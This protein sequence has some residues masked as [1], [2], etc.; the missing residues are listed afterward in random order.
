MVRILFFFLYC[1]A[2]LPS[3]AQ[4][5]ILL[6]QKKNKTVQTYYAGKFIS[7][8]TVHKNYAEGL[9][10]RITS[11]SVY[12]RHFDIQKSITEYG[13]V[14]FDTS[15]RYTTAIH[16]KD[17][18]G[19]FSRKRS[20]NNSSKGKLLLIAGGGV[21][22]LGAVN[23]L[24]RGDPPKNWY[25]ASSY[26]SAGVLSGLG[27]LLMRKATRRYGQGKKYR[28]KILKLDLR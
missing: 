18:G 3:I 11:D 8:E 6:L 27:V 9:I 22:V 17:I 19:L 13:G 21:M 1:A 7:L 23:G 26:I 12:I 10:T 24:Y 20:T 14:Y 28:F 2:S 16:V 25:K 15:F 4:N 5:N